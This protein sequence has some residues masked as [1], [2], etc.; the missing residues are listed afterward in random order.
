MTTADSPGQEL[1]SEVGRSFLEE[2]QASIYATGQFDTP[3]TADLT[4][5]YRDESEEKIFRQNLEIL[6]RQAEAKNTKPTQE[7]EDHARAAAHEVL[8]GSVPTQFEQPALYGIVK[9]L[10]KQAETAISA[11]LGQQFTQ[12]PVI[13]T[14]PTGQVNAMAIRVPGTDEHVI[15]FESQ[16]FTFC[17]LFSKAVT[18]ALPFHGL[19][20]DQFSMSTEMSEILDRINN[21][22][23]IVRRF[24]EVVAAYTVDGLPSQAPPYI[25]PEPWG[26]VAALFRD[27]MELFIMTHEFSHVLLEHTGR[28]KRSASLLGGNEAEVLEWSQQQEVEADALGILLLMGSPTVELDAAMRF[29]GVSLFFGAMT[30]V[31]RAVTLLQFGEERQL[32]STTHPANRERLRM[33]SQA[34]QACRIVSEQDHRAILQLADA[35]EGIIE[36]LWERTAPHIIALRERGVRPHRIWTGNSGGDARQRG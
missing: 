28:G 11:V 24:Y 2:L 25:P 12:R 35:V 27:L 32:I 10:A 3:R 22:P 8:Y 7:A 21:T 5:A 30:V 1:G 23:E 15:V 16:I 18:L 17:L 19:Q 34:A 13:G 9:A 36:T 31:E 14:L 26:S 29:V 4:Q 6:R 33:A 20:N